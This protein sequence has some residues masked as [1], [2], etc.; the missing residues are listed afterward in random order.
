M[1]APRLSRPIKGPLKGEGFD[2][3]VF[4]GCLGLA[5]DKGLEDIRAATADVVS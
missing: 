4:E 3:V 5:A 1:Y 2:E